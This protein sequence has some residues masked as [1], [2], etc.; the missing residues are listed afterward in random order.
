MLKNLFAAFALIAAP[1]LA[2]EAT[3]PLPAPAFDATAAQGDSE[4]AVLAGGCFWGMQ[5]VFQRVKGVKQV[6]SG[7]SGG[8]AV[9]A[10]YYVV[11]TGATGH[12]ESVQIVFD[13]HV[14]SYGQILQIYFSVMDPTTLDYQGPDTGSQYRS[15]IFAANDAQRKTAVGYIAQLT[16]EHAFSA[17]IVT[18]VSALHG[19]YAAEG[20]HQDYLLHHPDEP[21]I[22]VNDLPKVEKLHRFYPQLYRD[23][24]VTVAQ[25]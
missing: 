21:Y 6:L 3:H 23:H 10:H 15:E 24:P 8:G 19:F 1:A 11:G 13:P 2:D 5:G 14:V 18:R 20:Y 16:K 25:R 17:P 22:V 7:Y 4:T 12:A 9:S